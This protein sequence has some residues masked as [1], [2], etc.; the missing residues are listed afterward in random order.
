MDEKVAEVLMRIACH[1]VVRGPR[2]M[3]AEEAL[4]LYKDVLTIDFSSYCPH[5][6]PVVKRITRAEVDK[7]F[8]RT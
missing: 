3:R 4:A 5:G 7:M 8:G 2:P 1:S 6:R